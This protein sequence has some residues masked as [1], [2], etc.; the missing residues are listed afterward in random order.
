[1]EVNIELYL[2]L[3]CVILRFTT[4][5]N[6]KPRRSIRFTIRM[7]R[8]FLLLLTRVRLFSC[9]ESLQTPRYALTAAMF[10]SVTQEIICVRIT[11]VPENYKNCHESL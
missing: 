7:Y 9:I 1:M 8:I 11:W 5:S 2:F 4:I 10:S 6:E 3:A